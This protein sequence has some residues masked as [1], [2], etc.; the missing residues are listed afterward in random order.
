MNNQV[1]VSQND[2]RTSC[3]KENQWGMLCHVAAFS[4]FIIPF[5]NVI[6]PLVIWLLKKDEYYFVNE[7]GKEAINFQITML[8]ILF[9]CF[10]LCFAF[11]G[12]LLLPIFIIF[13][14]I[15]TIVAF[16]KAS[17]GISYRYPLCYQFIK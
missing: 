8:I 15:I 4:F 5:G 2:S 6:G 10:I 1:N 12:F 9:A 3:L 11:I 14:F 17:K 7:Q 13:N 16:S